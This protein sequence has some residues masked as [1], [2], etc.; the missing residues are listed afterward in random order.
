ML[1]D[2]G[3]I[4]TQSGLDYRT[5]RDFVVEADSL[6]FS[7]VSMSDHFFSRMP[8]IELPNLECWTTLSALSAETRKIR[9]CPLV[10]CNLY[11]YPAILAKVTSTLDVISGGRLIL[12]IG[13]GW[14]REECEAYGVPFPPGYGTRVHQ[15]EEA[16]QIVKSMWTMDKPSFEGKYYTIKN[17]V[18]EPKPVQKPSPPI[19][20]GGSGE[21]LMSVLCRH[22]DY[23]N[24]GS[25]YYGTPDEDYL[26]KLQLR[27]KCCKAI[28]RN[29]KDIKKSLNTI[30][31]IADSRKELDVK[32]SEYAR[33]F[34]KSYLDYKKQLEQAVVGTPE[35]CRSSLERY[36]N[37]GIDHFFL[38]FP[39]PFNKEDLRLFAQEAIS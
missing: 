9:L 15:L 28:G 30:V 14:H 1:A 29:P 10:L 17:A 25:F 35:E 39:D 34:G 8:P 13:A 24:F 22:S 21:K 11:R 3:V 2:F 18:C 4:I 33:K 19:L 6:G 12:G 16:I 31:F 20:V 26:R 7:S 36:V 5:I 32:I 23:F 27:E 38:S 37:M